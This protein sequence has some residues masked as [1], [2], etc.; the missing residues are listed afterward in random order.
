[1]RGPPA[2][3]R[4]KIDVKSTQNLVCGADVSR[5]LMCGAGPGDL[6]GSRGSDSAQIS[7]KTGPKISSLTAFR[8]PAPPPPKPSEGRAGIIS[9]PAGAG[10]G[11]PWI[12]ALPHT[13]LPIPRST[14]DRRAARQSRN[15]GHLKALWLEIFGPFF[16]GFTAESDPQDT[17]DCRGP[18]RTSMSTKKSAPQANSKA[19]WW[20]RT[21]NPAR[22]PSSTQLKAVRRDFSFDTIWP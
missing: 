14:A 7:G 8:Y 19:K 21:K 1:L 3:N 2:G 4:R 22:L 15:P 12:S 13:P 18:P 11:P 5:K 6:G 10:R 16:L 9:M 17:L 20:R